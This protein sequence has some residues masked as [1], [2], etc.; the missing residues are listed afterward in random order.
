MYTF[1]EDVYFM[2]DRSFVNFK[3]CSFNLLDKNEEGVA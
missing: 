2:I 1:K 3:D